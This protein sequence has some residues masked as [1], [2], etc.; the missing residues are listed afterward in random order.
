M[1]MWSRYDNQ[2]VPAV[3]GYRGGGD[4]FV[5]LNPAGKIGDLLRFWGA[6]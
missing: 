5:T 6:D 3:V 2:L 1:S 4:E